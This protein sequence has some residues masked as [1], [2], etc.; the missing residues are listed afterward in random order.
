VIS[1]WFKLNAKGSWS[2]SQPTPVST[3]M[4]KVETKNLDRLLSALAFAANIKKSPGR[5]EGNLTWPGDP[6]NIN[7]LNL[8]GK[9][10]MHFRKGAFVDLEP[11]AGR[12]FGLLN[13][14]ALQRRLSLDFTDFFGKGFAFDKIDG[15]FTL[16]S[17]D[18]F[19]HN[20]T[21]EAPTGV[22]EI[23]GRT[24]LISKD[25]DQ[26]VSVIP[27]VTGTLAT[28]GVL[29]GGPVV[30]AALFLTSKMIGKQLNKVGKTQYEVKGSWDKPI[31]KSVNARRYK[32]GKSS[33][34]GTPSGQRQRAPQGFDLDL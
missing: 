7:D 9:L 10:S 24:G 33:S 26:T 30:G 34:K 12:F 18:A 17:G 22:I 21:I 8:S 32:T 16:D 20:L 3:A 5:I 15:D 13:L 27:D 29:A 1:D 23:S 4:F 14:G 19:T 11:G 6:T 2:F 28:A 25:Y 31:I